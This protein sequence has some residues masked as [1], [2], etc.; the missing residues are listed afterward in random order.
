M[1]DTDIR[2]M[3]KATLA[4]KKIET[5]DKKVIVYNLNRV[6]V[7]VQ[8]FEIPFPFDG[9]IY[10]VSASLLTRGASETVIQIEKCSA[11]DYDTVPN[12]IPVLSTPLTIEANESS[13]RTSSV[14]HVIGNEQVSMDD[15]FRV[16]I[17]TAGQGAMV[18]NVEV[19]VKLL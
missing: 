6:V 4:H 3:N 17:L 7:G 16:N 5:I 12:W 11:V 18:L 14:P 8:R 2:S 15:Y 1:R 13:S 19:T 9:S 10:N